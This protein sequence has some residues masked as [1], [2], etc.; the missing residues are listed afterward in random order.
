MTTKRPTAEKA[1]R[2]SPTAPP[3]AS[4]SDAVWAYLDGQP[5]FRERLDTAEADLEAGKGT[6]YEVGAR[7]LRRVQPER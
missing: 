2:V 5:G 3:F 7:T 4:V 6:R 1:G